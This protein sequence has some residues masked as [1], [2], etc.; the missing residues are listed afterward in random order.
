[1][2]ARLRQQLANRALQHRL[3]QM[4]AG[5]NGSTLISLTLELGPG[6]DNWL[7]VLPER[8]P[9][10]YRAQPATGEYRLGI[11]HALHLGSDGRQRFAAL[12]NAYAGLTQDWRHTGHAV[13]FCGFAFADNGGNSDLPSALLAVPSLLLDSSAGQ[14]RVTLTTTGARIDEAVSHWTRLISQPA[15]AK[16]LRL[17]PETDRTLA[18][19]AWV[20]RVNAARRDIRLGHLDKLV[21]ARSRQL[22]SSTPIAARYLLEMLGGQQPDACIYA[23]SQGASTF[24]GATPERLVRLHNGQIVSDALAGTA[25]PGSLALKDSK[26]QHEHSLV[27]RAIVAALA[28]FC[29]NS[30][31]ADALETHQAGR[32]SH[33]RNRITGTALAT[34]T[35]FD[36]LGA[37]HPTPAVGGYPTA[38]AQEWLQAHAEQ[39]CGWYSGGIGILDGTGNGDFSVALRS[40]L[41]QDTR[42]ELHAGAGIVADSDP[43]QEL[44][45]TDAKLSTLLDV[46]HGTQ[47][48]RQKSR[49]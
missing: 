8:Q 32:V 28:P 42:I 29:Q 37:L 33:L 19:R 23:F 41:I 24:L 31:T 26:N 30:P 17:L 18:E 40:A 6:S 22:Q 47:S 48:A 9:Y 2:I 4:A 12:G 27:V 10:W 43:W 13:A 36:L 16:P 11:G 20:A 39:R 14:C 45:E 35:I 49:S 44:A 21:L 34:T 3:H 46:L 1:M 7:G 15:P 38:A 25:W 5:A